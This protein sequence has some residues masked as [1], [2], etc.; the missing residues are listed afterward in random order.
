MGSIKCVIVGDGARGKTALLF[1]METTDVKC[2]WEQFKPMEFS[3]FDTHKLNIKFR[4]ADITVNLQDTPGQVILINIFLTA[5]Y[6]IR[7][8]QTFFF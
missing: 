3:M 7:K 4:G 2:P 5:W 8:T 1:S 6:D